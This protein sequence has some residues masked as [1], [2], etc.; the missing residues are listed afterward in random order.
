MLNY[1]AAQRTPA[2]ALTPE[3][4]EEIQL[5]FQLL[6][7]TCSCFLNLMNQG[8]EDARF[9]VTYLMNFESTLQDKFPEA[10][11]EK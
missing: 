4:I 5:A 8:N 11:E 2:E 3:N 9:A 1:Y 6:Q 7:K 10:F